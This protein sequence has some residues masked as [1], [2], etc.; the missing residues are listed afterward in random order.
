MANA[1]QTEK[2]TPTR[3]K[4]AKDKG[5]FA[6]SQEVTGVL[7]LFACLGVAYVMFSNP[8]GYR[9]FFETVLR[10][11]ISSD[12]DVNMTALVRQSGIYFLMVAGPIFAAAIVAAV[13]GNVLQ[14]LPIFASES[15][16]LNWD[17]LNPV[18]GLSRLKGK[19]SPLEWVKILF[20][21]AAATGV[22][23]ST[24][25]LFWPQLIMAPALSIG[26]SNDIV[27]AMLF[28]IVTYLGVALVVMATGDFFLQ[29]YKFE[30]SIKMS[31]AEV[32]EDAK[33]M[34]GNPT[35]KGKIRSIQRERARRR[36]MDRVKDADV[37]VT[38]PTHYA[39]ALEYKPGTMSA[40]RVIAKGRGWLAQRIKA[41]GRDHDIPTVENVPL[42][43]ALYRSVEIDQEIPADLFK[44]VAEVLAF[45]Y[46]T[47][48]QK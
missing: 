23:W 41:E 13:V 34:E 46:R 12:S 40:P 45:V 8:T 42:A 31:K 32:K 24:M 26:A 30:K 39:V 27:V 19:I 43:R 6:Y 37:I 28:R 47:R 20:L 1:E 44:A 16:G 7:T 18:A 17:R 25:R 33:S 9:A 22:M 38:N 29:R 11:G 3:R 14:G 21:I 15:L 36:M 5:Q 35:I 4:K 10:A 2:A 48:K